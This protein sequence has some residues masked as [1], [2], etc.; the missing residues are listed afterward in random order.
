[1]A[2]TRHSLFGKMLAARSTAIKAGTFKPCLKK[3]QMPIFQCLIAEDG[4]PQEWF[5][6]AEGGRTLLGDCLIRSFGEYP[7]VANESSLS[8]ILEP[9]AH[10]KYS[11]SAKAS[12]GILKRAARRKKELPPLLSAIL[13]LRAGVKKTVVLQISDEP[14][15]EFITTPTNQER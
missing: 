13:K 14:P 2:D 3:S 6:V 11:L 8:E 10:P 7:N 1:M 15:T 4:Q 5:E 9:N 12:L